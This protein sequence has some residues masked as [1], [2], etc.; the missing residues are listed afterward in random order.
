MATVMVTAMVKKRCTIQHLA[1]LS[2]LA[3]GVT[4]YSTVAEDVTFSSK[5]STKLTYSDNINLSSQ[6]E[7]SGAVSVWSAGVASDIQGTE[8]NLL[9]NYDVYQ[10]LHSVDSGRNEL[11]NELSLSAS[12]NLYRNN[13]TLSADASIT[14]VAR[15]VQDNAN[16]DII[17]GGTIETRSLSSQISYQ[18]NPRGYVDLFGALSAKTTSNS[19]SIGDYYSVG[20]DASFKNGTSVKNYF[21]LSD[22]TYDQNISRL[23]DNF[24]FSFSTNNELGL[25][26]IYNLSPFIR[27]NYEGYSDANGD[28]VIESGSWGPALRYYLSKRSYLEL[29]YDFSFYD[30]DFWRGAFRLEPNSRTLITFDYTK[31]YYGDAYE[32]S[33]THRTKKLTNT[34]S[35]TEELIGF[36]REFFTEGENIEEYQLV[37]KANA[38]STLSLKRTS[39]TFEVHGSERSPIEGNDEMTTRR[40]IGGKLSMSHKLSSNTSFSSSF[41]YDKN[42][43]DSTNSGGSADYYRFLDASLTNQFSKSISW[44]LSVRNAN[45]SL[46]R[47]NRANVGIY[48]VY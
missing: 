7:Q 44:D 4:S 31:R 18:S 13:I 9:F 6:D 21:W 29:S 39:F 11:F 16:A 22:F 27:A 37:K 34:I 32:F 43:F 10:T 33:L 47:E 14:N 45:S 23:N 15:S 40:F 36:D 5:A 3:G 48:V 1:W 42:I 17:S 24:Y 28:N 19:D 41:Q 38:D 2:L 8:G 30:E 26:P 12:K 25:Q 46:Y 20:A 35:Y